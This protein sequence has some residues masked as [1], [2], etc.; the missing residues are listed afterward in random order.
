MF[1]RIKQGQPLLKSQF[2]SINRGDGDAAVINGNTNHLI[3]MQ[4]RGL[5]HIGR[6]ANPQVVAPFFYAKNGW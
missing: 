1:C 5:C 3:W 6:Q 4:A 2:Q